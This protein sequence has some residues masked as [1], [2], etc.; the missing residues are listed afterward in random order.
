[1]CYNIEICLPSFKNVVS[2]YTFLFTP[3]IV[4]ISPKEVKL[5]R[6]QIG[7]ELFNLT[8]YIVRVSFLTHEKN[9]KYI[10]HND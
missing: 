2:V 9:E 4:N 1:M 3:L 6:L 8:L 5:L 7:L 10:F